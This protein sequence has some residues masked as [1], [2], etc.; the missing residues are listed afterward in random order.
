MNNKIL[1][2]LSILLVSVSAC[3]TLE[4]RPLQ[5]VSV[6]ELAQLEVQQHASSSGTDQTETLTLNAPKQANSYAS[7]NA[8]T[9]DEN[10]PEI[11]I[12]QPLITSTITNPMSV[13]VE[14]SSR[15]PD[16]N[17]NMKSLKL[18]YKKYWGIDLTDRIVDYI[19]GDAIN[20]PEVELPEGRHTLEIYI[21]DDQ[22]NQSI[23]LITVDIAEG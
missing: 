17:V 4:P 15:Q 5:L 19:E 12:L 8:A 7:K 20:A 16:S 2:L 23:R 10:G 14:F 21:E 9:E 3:S 11:K 13:H 22:E 6:A 1:L 18:I